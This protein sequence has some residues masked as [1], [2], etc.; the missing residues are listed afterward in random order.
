MKTVGLTLGKYAPLHRGHQLVIE[1]ALAEVDEL[2]VL[3]YDCPGVTDIPLETRAGW[4]RT[5]Y[6][7]VSVREVRGG[8]EETGDTPAITRR[9][10]QFIIGELGIRGITHFYTSEFYGHHLSRALGAV[11]RRIDPDRKRVPVSG[12]LV[13][14]DPYRY[15][16]YLDP[17]VYRSYVKN[18][19]LTGAPSTGKT[20][21]A[22]KLAAAYA[23][24]WMP[25]YGREYWD[26]H[27]VDRRLT[28][29]Q[30]VEIAVGHRERE[31]KLLYQADRFL[32]TDTSALTTWLFAR[33]YHGRALPELDR[34]AAA[35]D[36][37]Y[38]LIFFCG[39]DIPY[40]DTG[41][42]SGPVMREE[43]QAELLRE[44][45][46]REMAYHPVQGTVEERLALVRNALTV[47]WPHRPV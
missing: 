45:E 4:I 32:F 34:L 9:H 33:H 42:R 5:L 1:T 10:E 15:R 26:L 19:L 27:Q 23:T 14:S 46:Q 35:A 38:D 31:E 2:I 11:D 13:R 29:E 6:P 17:L 18:I 39:T 3:I 25:E 30:L 7:T 44:L 28:P 8:P 36:R 16:Q 22:E 20:T 21:L 43:F 47:N 24:V 37:R 41:D 12:T 40:D